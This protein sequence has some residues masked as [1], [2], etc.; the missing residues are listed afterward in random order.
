M[1]SRGRCQ[2]ENQSSERNRVESG[3]GVFPLGKHWGGQGVSDRALHAMRKWTLLPKHPFSTHLSFTYFI[4]DLMGTCGEFVVEAFCFRGQ[5][6]VSFRKQ[7]VIKISGQPLNRSGGDYSPN[8]SL[9]NIPKEL[10][11][12]EQSSHWSIR[13]A[14]VYWAPTVSKLLAQAWYMVMDE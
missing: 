7:T 4:P 2:E 14:H 13:S 9:E 1:S 5:S 6:V 3:R 11:I 12:R 8:W 10:S